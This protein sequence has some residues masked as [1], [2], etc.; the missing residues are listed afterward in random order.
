MG[1]T[2]LGLLFPLLLLQLC[3][4]SHSSLPIG[5]HPLDQKFYESRLIK[6]KDGSK[7]FTRDRINDNFCDCPDGSDEPGTSACPSGKFYCKNVGSTP[8]F[9]YSSH[10]ND[11]ICDCCDGSDEYDGTINC[12]NTCF[13]GGN[14]AYH[15]ISRDPTVR[16]QNSFHTGRNK[17]GLNAKESTEK[18]TG[19]KV[20]LILQVVF[21]TLI[22]AYWA[23][24]RRYRSRRRHSL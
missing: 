7:S 19:L 13:T 4:F 12:P 2:L 21:V 8:R 11:H 20:L 6:C 9:L 10:V 1:A 23:H 3:Q 17:L 18:H 22:M 16:Q 15:S 24:R 14:I 5:A